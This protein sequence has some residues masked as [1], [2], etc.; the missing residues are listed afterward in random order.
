M[1]QEFNEHSIKR[2]SRL[3]NQQVDEKNPNWINTL[4]RTNLLE[5]ETQV[6]KLGYSNEKEFYTYHRKLPEASAWNK[7]P[8]EENPL[9]RYKFTSVEINHSPDH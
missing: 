9:T 2:H 5:D 1:Q 6:V 3:Y 7:F 4:I 8:T